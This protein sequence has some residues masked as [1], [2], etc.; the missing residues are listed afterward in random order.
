MTYGI[1]IEQVSKPL[2]SLAVLTFPQVKH[3]TGMIMAAR[4]YHSQ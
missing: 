2:S 3:R 1:I 4:L